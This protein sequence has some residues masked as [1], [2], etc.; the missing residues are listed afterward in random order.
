MCSDEQLISS[1]TAG[2]DTIFTVN[3]VQIPILLMAIS[4]TSRQAAARAASV[5]EH[6]FGEETRDGES[7]EYRRCCAVCGYE[8]RYE[9]M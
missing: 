1:S 8:M 3:H 6:K 2:G 9:K 4:G 7:G 5:H